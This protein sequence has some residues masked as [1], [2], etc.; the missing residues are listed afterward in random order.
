M[1]VVKLI[2]VFSNMLVFQDTQCIAEY[3]VLVIQIGVLMICLGFGFGCSVLYLL[4]TT[5][6]RRLNHTH[7]LTSAKLTFQSFSRDSLQL[8]RSRSS[9]E[10]V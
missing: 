4:S 10:S 8:Y 7:Y 6:Q 3:S 1:Y 5:T 2:N 9:Y